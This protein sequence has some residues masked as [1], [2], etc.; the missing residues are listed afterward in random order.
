MP[1]AAH[2][3]RLSTGSAPR[4][5]AVAADGFLDGSMDGSGA[6]VAPR[7]GNRCTPSRKPLHPVV[8]AVAPRSC[9][10]VQRLHPASLIIHSPASGAVGTRATRLRTAGSRSPCGQAGKLIFKRGKVL[11]VQVIPDE[12]HVQI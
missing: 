10:G 12:A 6:T 3:S 2:A 8:E 11:G 5:P 7:P 9:C 4:A 1:S